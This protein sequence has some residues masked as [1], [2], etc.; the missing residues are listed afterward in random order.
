VVDR[1]EHSRLQ[2]VCVRTTQCQSLP[3]SVT[4]EAAR[5]G[6]A[7]ETRRQTCSPTNRP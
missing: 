5:T 1:L 7:I 4:Q 6:A 2:T 3:V